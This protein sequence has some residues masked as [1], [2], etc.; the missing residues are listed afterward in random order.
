[1]SNDLAATAL[2]TQQHGLITRAQAL[3]LGYSRH[4]IQQRRASGVWIPMDHGVY[5]HHAYGVTW[6]NRLLAVCLGTGAVAS[7]RS[8]A[9]LWELDG[10]RAG[11][12]EVVLPAGSSIR[13]PD[14]RVHETTQWDRIGRTQRQGIPCTSLERTLIDLAAVVGDRRLR[15]AVD[16]ARRRQLTDW[17]TLTRTLV[18]HARRGRDGAARFRSLLEQHGGEAAIPRSDWSRVVADLLVDAGLPKPQLE[19][20]VCDDDG[21]RAE[22]DL[23]YPSAR[24]G[25][26]LD[27]I[28]WHF[29][30]EAFHRD[31]VRRNRLT[32]LGW[33]V[34]N[35]TWVEFTE[36]ADRLIRTVRAAIERRAASPN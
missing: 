15:Q 17:P 22:L 13:R 23:A 8:A 27:S 12:P 35:F 4:Q 2:L 36:H 3:H 30:H 9:W 33:Q 24:V 29:N 7:H 1:M 5:R 34:L 28:T 10:S 11:R 16:C 25:I 20:P 26:E 21:F 6:A 32:V 18:Q 31:P 14:V 19:Y